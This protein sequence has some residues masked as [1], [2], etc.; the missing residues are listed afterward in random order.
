MDDGL[1]CMANPDIEQNTDIWHSCLLDQAG[2]EHSWLKQML[3]ILPVGVIITDLDGKII[4]FN[5]EAVRIHRY[6]LEPS[7]KIEDFVGWRL[8]KGGRPIEPEDFPLYRVFQK[9][10]VVKNDEQRMLHDDGTTTPI[11]VDAAPIYD[12]Q[13]HIAYAMVVITDITEKER[14]ESALTGVSRGRRWR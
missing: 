12:E 7:Y 10:E 4:I 2:S 1:C 6:N 8:L 14:C 5:R 3:E 13:G 9:G 11:S